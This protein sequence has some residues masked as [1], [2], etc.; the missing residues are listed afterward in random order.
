LP[1]GEL[2]RACGSAGGL[3]LVVAEVDRDID[4]LHFS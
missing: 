1:Q 4:D 3:G 2:L